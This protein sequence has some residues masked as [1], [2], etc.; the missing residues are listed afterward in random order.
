MTLLSSNSLWQTLPGKKYLPPHIS[1]NPEEAN[2]MVE[3]NIFLP[4][5]RNGLVP[6]T[7]AQAICSVHL[8]IN[9]GCM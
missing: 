8:C 7:N 1:I 2:T 9:F 5:Q 3:R 4:G 6:D